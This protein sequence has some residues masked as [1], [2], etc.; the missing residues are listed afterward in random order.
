MLDAQATELC[1][2][3]N[4]HGSDKGRRGKHN[5]TCLYYALLRRMRDKP[6]R[7]FELGI[8][9][10]TQLAST[11]GVDGRPGASLRRWLNLCQQLKYS[12]RHRS[13][14]LFTDDRIRTFWCDQTLP[15]VIDAMWRDLDPTEEETGLI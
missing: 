9:R 11:M 8:G 7:I 13:Y 10:T 2:V 14:I 3:M 12:A 6:L 4:L 15:S 1:D 5:Y